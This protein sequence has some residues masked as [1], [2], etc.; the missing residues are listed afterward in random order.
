LA[1]ISKLGKVPDV[2]VEALE[3]RE[4]ECGYRMGLASPGKV[5]K[6]KGFVESCSGC[7]GLPS[8][9]C[10]NKEWIYSQKKTG[11]LIYINHC[12]THL[13]NIPS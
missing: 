10:M 13:Q 4:E 2:L 3:E 5:D 1:S 9:Y 8:F 11:K 12:G 7:P 6:G